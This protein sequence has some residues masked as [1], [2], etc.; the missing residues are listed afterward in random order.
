MMI[1][2]YQ[3][4]NTENK[5]KLG[6]VGSHLKLNH[7]E[8]NIEFYWSTMAEILITFPAIQSSLVCYELWPE[9]DK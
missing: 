1:L 2:I 4:R 6:T 8:Q 3:S 5:K 7:F 9:F